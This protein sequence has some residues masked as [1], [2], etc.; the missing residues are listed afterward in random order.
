MFGKTPARKL[1]RLRPHHLLCT[2]GYEGKGYSKAFIANMTRVTNRLRGCPAG[3]VELTFS[4]DDICIKCPHKTKENSCTDIAKVNELDQKVISCFKLKERAYNYHTLIS[5]I[6]NHM[7]EAL[8]DDI[9]GKC[10]WYP[11]SSCKKNI[12]NKIHCLK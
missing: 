10:S 3:L 11:V 6:D 2:Q 7:T 4:A 5:D 9:C 8:M 1:I 12:L